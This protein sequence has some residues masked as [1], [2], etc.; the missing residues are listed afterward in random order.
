MP[1]WQSSPVKLTPWGPVA[2]TFI[3][4]LFE[5]LALAD[6]IATRL[7]VDGARERSGHVQRVD[8]SHASG[9]GHHEKAG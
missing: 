7:R 8:R 6:V 1:A 5:L 4:A 2:K 3:S 9:A